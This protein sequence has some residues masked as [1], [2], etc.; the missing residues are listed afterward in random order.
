MLPVAAA[1]N[2]PFVSAYDRS[3]STLSLFRS[4]PVKQIGITPEYGSTTTENYKDTITL[5]VSGVEKSRQVNDTESNGSKTVDTTNAEQHL[6][7]KEQ[8]KTGSQK[9]SSA[10][11]KVIQQLQKRDREVK[12]HE[13]AHLANAGQYAR[14]GP[15]YSYQQGPD[16]QRYAIGG[17]VPIDIGKEKTPEQTIQKMQAVERAALAPADPSSADRSIAAAAAA[18]EIQARQEAQAL[19]AATASKQS[20]SGDRP[21]ATGNPTMK[22]DAGPWQF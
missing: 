21:P 5:S 10:E 4:E 1:S 22:N 2:A 14:G 18:M 19:Q 9:F 13:Q 20:K 11:E 8:T 7:T 3:G 12:V 6:T 15:T 16:G 17:E